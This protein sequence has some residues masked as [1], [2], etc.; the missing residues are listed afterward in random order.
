[1]IQTP[2]NELFEWTQLD[3]PTQIKFLQNG[4]ITING[5]EATTGGCEDLP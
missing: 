3:S 1:M 5:K 2:T 4:T